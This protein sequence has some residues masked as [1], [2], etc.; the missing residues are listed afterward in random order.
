MAITFVNSS[1]A[2]AAGGAALSIAAPASIL[3]DDVLYAFVTKQATGAWTIT[4]SG[5]TQ[6]VDQD[7]TG[8]GFSVNHEVWRKVMG[9]SP[10]TSID[11]SNTAAAKSGLL[12]ALRGVDTT[13]PEDATSTIAFSFSSN[14]DSPSI[15]TVTNGAWVLSG[16]GNGQNDASITSPTGYSNQVA[17]PRNNSTTVVATKE[18][19]T[20]GAEDPSAWTTWTNTGAWVAVSIAVR[21]AGTAATTNF[22]WYEQTITAP[23]VKPRVLDAFVRPIRDGVEFTTPTPSIMGWFESFGIPA[24]PAQGYR[25]NLDAQDP[26]VIAPPATLT[27]DIGWF[28]PY[29]R[30]APGKTQRALIAWDPQPYT[31]TTEIG[32]FTPYGLPPP[33]KRA[34]TDAAWD[35]QSIAPPATLTTDLGWFVPY[36]RQLSEGKAPPRSFAMDPQSIAAVTTLTTDI[37]WYEPYARPQAKVSLPISAWVSVFGFRPDLGLGWY[38]P[39]TIKPAARQR[40]ADAFVRGRAEALP[41]IGWFEPYPAI[42]ARRRALPGGQSFVASP[43]DVAGLGWYFSFTVPPRRVSLGALVWAIEITPSEPA[44]PAVP[45]CGHLTSSVGI[46]ADLIPGLSQAGA[47][48]ETVSIA[49]KATASFSKTATARVTVSKGGSLKSDI[50]CR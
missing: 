4:S 13:T 12:I 50:T 5:W 17:S 45:D 36:G 9:A 43:P 33:P 48:V 18:V 11:F 39:Y 23:A 15:T 21:P 24:K 16:A 34:R 47:M 19:T 49:G 30:P 27:T 1:I 41:S 29:G 25:Y 31:L 28:Q 22:G 38:E 32:W 35:P 20:A 37:G 26:Q 40:P 2:N 3:Q 8:G 44:P 42:G 10:D 7:S 6:L 46:G 14:P